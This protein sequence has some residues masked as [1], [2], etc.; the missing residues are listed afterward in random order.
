M[1]NRILKLNPV[2]FLFLLTITLVACGNRPKGVL[3]DMKMENLLYD[4]HLAEGEINNN[5][6]LFASDSIRKENLLNSVLKKHKVT[7]NQLDASIDWYAG[8]LDRYKKIGDNLSSRFEKDIQVLRDIASQSQMKNNPDLVELPFISD[9]TQFFN[10]YYLPRN[11][12]AFQT[13]TTFY[14]F[15]GTYEVHFNVLGINKTN[16]PELTFCV[17]CAEIGRAHV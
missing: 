15:G 8:N 13:D 16:N 4:L 11:V 14:K 6:S 2:I 9:S 5:H 10:H 1:K 17:E 7:R 3:S 12:F